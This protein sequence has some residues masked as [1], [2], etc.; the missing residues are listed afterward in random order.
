MSSEIASFLKEVDI[1]SPLSDEER[2]LIASVLTVHEYDPGEALFR[3]GEAGTEMFILRQ[4]EIGIEMESSG[5]EAME[6]ASLT[7][8]DFLGEMSIFE[9]APRSATCRSKGHTVLYALSM[10][11]FSRLMEER[12]LVAI[13]VMNRMLRIVASRLHRSSAFLSE[14]VQWGESARRR[15]ITDEFTGLFNRRF[16]DDA[17][18]TQFSRARERGEPL[19]FVMIDL[20]HFNQLNNAYGHDVG[21]E[22]I[23]AASEVF[24]S[25]FAEEDIVA[26]YGGDEFAA[27]L[28]GTSGEEAFK[29]CEEIR[30]AVA[31]LELLAELK[32][33]V[34]RV[35]T[36]Q[37][38]ASFP[39]HGAD[40]KSVWE[41]ADRALYVAKERGRNCVV[42]GGMVEV[43]ND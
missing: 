9:D 28:P 15:S 19:S 41:A 6:I 38:V 42:L 43:K 17:L 18:E 25:R 14:M 8:G 12:P 5:G 39:E 23:K 36:S 30:S 37:G 34:S 20:D 32:G 16:F 26:R 10:D 24:K 40:I 1:F 2:D 27:L 7:A 21:D 35:T 31:G 4:G 29:R 33:P 13:R 11:E 3:E 22:V